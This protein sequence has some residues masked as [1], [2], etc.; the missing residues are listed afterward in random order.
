MP[1]F[2]QLETEYILTQTRRIAASLCLLVAFVLAA[3]IATFPAFKADRPALIVLFAL[4]AGLVL[5]GQAGWRWPGKAVFALLAV[6]ALAIPAVVIA[7]S[8]GRIDMFAVLF[9]VHIGMEGAGIGA[10]K[11]EIIQGV[12]SVCVVVLCVLVLA[13]LW[14]LR[15]RVLW[16]AALVMLA[17]NPVSQFAVLEWTRPPL[18]SDL[19]RHLTPPLTAPDAKEVGDIVVIYV[20]GTDRQ[21]ADPAV[22]GDSY[23]G[24]NDLSRQGLALTGV[25]QVT[26]TAW[27]VAGM[28]ASLCGVPALPRGLAYRNNYDG[29]ERFIPNI[30]CLG[31]V[32]KPLGYRSSFVV[33]GDL[34]YS[35]VGQLYSDH[36]FQTVLGRQELLKLLPADL[37]QKSM[38]DW[39]LDDSA[40]MQ[41]ARDEHA[42]LIA[43]DNPFLLVVETI[44]PHGKVG[45]L[46][47]DC[48]E[49]DIGIL[50]SNAR[51]VLK[52]TIAAVTDF[53]AHVQSEQKAKR[54]GRPLHIIIQSDHLSHNASAPAV[55]EEF[56]GANTVIYISPNVAPGT[57][58]AREASMIDV[59]ATTLEVTG[60]SAPPV[61]ANLGRSLLS[62][63]KTL[64]EQHGRTRLDDLFAR[65]G[66][67]ATKVWQ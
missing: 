6:A 1:E 22:W 28:M 67:L 64:R 10:I 9:H 54:P 12:V 51:A 62:A 53:V 18:N 32:V 55:A 40:V 26:G 19:S 43:G 57:Q 60:L 63:P 29:V 50:S 30:R 2:A 61:S 46:S 14:S 21:F 11:N 23:A 38:I 33:G 59:F 45:F 66:E 49:N 5:A 13:S 24:L 36:A 65:D 17:V 37:L 27:S 41:A 31:D 20:E 44:G 42:R 8:F 35:G 4:L 25:R 15:P 47:H 56:Q 7:R 16:G 48:T 34:T 58:I 39:V 3:L 52:C